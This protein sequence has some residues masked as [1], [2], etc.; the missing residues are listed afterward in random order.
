M[1]LSMYAAQR[2]YM[3][4]NNKSSN[5]VEE[6]SLLLFQASNG[7]VV[8]EFLSHFLIISQVLRFDFSEIMLKSIEKLRE[9]AYG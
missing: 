5:H 7:N 4:F 2:R 1:D 6:Q 8:H 9:I 3:Y